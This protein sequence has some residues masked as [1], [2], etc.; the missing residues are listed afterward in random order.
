MS[1][2]TLPAEKARDIV[3]EENEEVG[4][5]NLI[6]IGERE[7]RGWPTYNDIK[8]KNCPDCLVRLLKE[9]DLIKIV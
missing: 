1:H 8:P 5:Y 9:G 3:W 7:G 6:K 4:K 2:I